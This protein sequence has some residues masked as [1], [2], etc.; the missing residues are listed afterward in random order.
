MKICNG[1]E[2]SRKTESKNQEKK[3]YTPKSIRSLRSIV[4]ELVL[5]DEKPF[6]ENTNAY[7]DYEYEYTDAIGDELRR[8]L[9]R[10][11]GTQTAE[12]F[13]KQ[14]L[15][16]LEQYVAQTLLLTSSDENEETTDDENEEEKDKEDEEDEEEAQMEGDEKQ[17]KEEMKRKRLVEREMA[18]E[19]ARA[20]F[21]MLKRMMVKKKY[22]LATLRVEKEAAN[23]RNTS[24]RVNAIRKSASLVKSR[25]VTAANE[26]NNAVSNSSAS[27]FSNS[28]NANN[29]NKLARPKTVNI[30]PIKPVNSVNSMDR[31]DTVESLKTG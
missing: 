5:E 17:F 24:N 26:T 29:N 10:Y 2:S 11:D 21:L 16:P 3:L 15:P 13:L 28:N 27:F 14:Q 19:R 4:D 30:I 7:D 31:V 18:L 25:P 8:L 22:V 12:L 9:D 6:E 1:I 20:S 23:R